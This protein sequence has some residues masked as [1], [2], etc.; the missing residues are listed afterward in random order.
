VGAHDITG[1]LL[2]NELGELVDWRSDDRLARSDGGTLKQQRWSTPVRDYRPFGP[3]RLASRGEGR[4]HTE[5]GAWIYIE[6]ELVD[7][8]ING[9]GVG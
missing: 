8:E 2:F 3:L 4:W 5:D 1:E 9:R 6:L 7:H